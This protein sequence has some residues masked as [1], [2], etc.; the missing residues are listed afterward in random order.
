MCPSDVDI[1]TKLE[2]IKEFSS[3]P[4]GL[5][6]FKSDKNEHL[7]LIYSLDKDCTDV[8]KR[9]F[10]FSKGSFAKRKR[11]RLSILDDPY[12]PRQAYPGSE[13]FLP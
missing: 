8:D 10:N 5:G 2:S 1:K 3:S 11:L 6:S 12:S 4:N 13:D 7:F 9:I